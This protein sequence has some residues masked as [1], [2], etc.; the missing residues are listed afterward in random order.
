MRPWSR[1]SSPTARR[2]ALAVARR[3][4]TLWRRL[5]RGVRNG[6]DYLR[7]EDPRFGHATL[8]RKRAAAQAPALVRALAALP[9]ASHSPRRA[10]WLA[11]RLIAVERAIP[12][13]PDVDALLEAHRP[14]LVL[15]TPLVEVGSEEVEYV[16]S[17][18]ALGYTSV[19]CVAGSGQSDQ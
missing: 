2:S 14:D 4:A 1:A 9:P 11:R 5:L 18:R 7:Y 6:A 8:L 10:R 15:V 17:A 19:L 16:M 13:A 3:G 12:N